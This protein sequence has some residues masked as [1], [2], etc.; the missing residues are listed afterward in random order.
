MSESDFNIYEQNTS[1]LG[2]PSP[3]K[4]EDLRKKNSNSCIDVYG[5]SFIYG[6]FDGLTS[7]DLWSSHL[8]KKINCKVGNYG[9]SGYGN[10]QVYLHFQKNIIQYKKN[11][12]VVVFAI[13]SINIQR[14]LNRFRGLLR[15]HYLPA[16]KP[17]F[18]LN[19]DKLRLI[20]KY[21]LDYKSYR[22]IFNDS[23]EN[24]PEF[25]DMCKVHSYITQKSKFPFSYHIPKS[26]FTSTKIK[27]YLK[28]FSLHQY[29]Y[30]TNYLNSLNIVQRIAKKFYQGLKDNNFNGVVLLIP[31][32]S[33]IRFLKKNKKNQFVNLISFL[34]SNNIPFIDMTTS[35]LEIM[36]INQTVPEKFFAPSGHLSKQGH[37]VLS[38]TI[39]N[40]YQK[41]D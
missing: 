32:L 27:S 15:G 13:T 39:A 25:E 26:I 12:P 1:A 3:K 24:C 36:K 8:N 41:T 30:K 40:F 37:I 19:D 28:G 4:L 23:Q 31:T 5:D 34:K 7:N 14:N 10:D 9:V 29:L 18:I 17:R 38:E 6:E 11:S 35:I 2:W 16:S 22:R 33:D 21:D 20:K